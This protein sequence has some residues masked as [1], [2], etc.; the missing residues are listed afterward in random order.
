M[1]NSEYVSHTCTSHSPIRT[2]SRRQLISSATLLTG[3][4]LIGKAHSI[5]CDANPSGTTDEDNCTHEGFMRI[6]IE[7][8]NENPRYPF[9]AII[10]HRDSGN[11]IAEGLNHSKSN[12]VLHAEIDAINHCATNSNGYAWSELDLYTTAEPCPMCQ[13]AI[14]WAGIQNVYYGTSIPYLQSLHW[15]QINIRAEE[16]SAKTPFRKTHI[17]GGILEKTCNQLFLGAGF[18]RPNTLKYRSK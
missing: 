2:L 4:L 13:S 15:D 10:V 6:A 5:T 16:I 9:A 12:P 1:K 3:S 18:F 7:L 14:E 11:I 17:T 8:A